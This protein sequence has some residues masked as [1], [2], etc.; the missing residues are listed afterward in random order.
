MKH[1]I[2]TRALIAI[3]ALFLSLVGLAMAQQEVSPD[4]F[5]STSVQDQ[6]VSKMSSKARD[7][8]VASNRAQ[9]KRASKVQRARTQTS[10]SKKV[11]G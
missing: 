10:S 4:H 11:S 1:L 9:K 2:V 7:K 6:Q 5:D 3:L 8:K